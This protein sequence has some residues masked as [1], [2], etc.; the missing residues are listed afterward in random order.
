M[1]QNQ[2]KNDKYSD[3]SLRKMYSPQI[4]FE[5]INTTPIFNKSQVVSL[6][7]SVQRLNI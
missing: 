6:S 7:Y 1:A 5:T 2:G 4:L 3:F